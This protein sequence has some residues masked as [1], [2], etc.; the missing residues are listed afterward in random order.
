MVEQRSPQRYYCYNLNGGVTDEAIVRPLGE[1]LYELS[2]WYGK[3]L[4]AYLDDSSSVQTIVC[5]TLA[6]TLDTLRVLRFEV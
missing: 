3:R 5:T 4:G 2:Y 6:E 1:G